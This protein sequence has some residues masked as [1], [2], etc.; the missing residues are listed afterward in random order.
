MPFYC[1]HSL[2]PWYIFEKYR[3]LAETTAIPVSLLM[4]TSPL[5]ITCYA[6]EGDVCFLLIISLSALSEH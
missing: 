2:F 3:L 4:I 1:C 6:Y 5:Y